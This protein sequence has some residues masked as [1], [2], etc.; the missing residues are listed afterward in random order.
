L[1]I[2]IRVFGQGLFLLVA[3]FIS[4]NAQGASDL[5]IQEIEEEGG[6]I[7]LVSGL[8]YKV[9]KEGSGPKP[10]INDTVVTHYHGTF[11]DGSM[12]DSS[13]RRGTPATFPVNGVIRG[14]TEALQLMSVGSKWRL[15][16]PPDLAYGKRGMRGAIP[17]NA[18][19]I[20]EVELLDIR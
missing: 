2:L 5:T 19:L 7:Q 16:I 15:V 4:Q 3:S 17:P 20:F 13:V 11:L 10:S 6:L 12:F 8:R 18:T 14:W 1:S 9:I